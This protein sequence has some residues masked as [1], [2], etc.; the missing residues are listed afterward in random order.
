[1]AV[2]KLKRPCAYPGCP[3]LVERGYC[4]KHKRSKDYNR[5]TAAQRGYG[6]KWRK[7]RELFL[8]KHPICARCPDAA[9]V[10]D[11][12]IP[13]KGNQT[14]FWDRSNWQPLCKRCHDKKTAT[15]DR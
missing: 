8:N 7:A 2:N 9:T 5:G 13:H 15:E 3:E 11:H 10:V 4:E 12:I 6:H 1:M 14:L